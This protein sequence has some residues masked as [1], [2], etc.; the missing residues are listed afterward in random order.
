[1]LTN[2]R[3]VPGLGINA[4]FRPLFGGVD[5]YLGESGLPSLRRLSDGLVPSDEY[6]HGN[7]VHWLFAD[8]HVAGHN[9]RDAFEGP[10]NMWD[11]D[12]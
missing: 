8:S 10:G 2:P 11:R 7:R 1:M 6:P 9:P 4:Q 3:L 5:G 12:R